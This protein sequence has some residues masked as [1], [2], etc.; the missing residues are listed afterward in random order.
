MLIDLML[1][2]AVIFC[3][4]QAVRARR[5]LTAVLWLAACSA[6][7][8]SLIY[9]TG[10]AETA[11]IELSVGAGLVTVLF[12]FCIAMIGRNVIKA[13]SLVPPR[14]AWLLLGATALFLG[15]ALWPSGAVETAVIS[16]PSFSVVFWEDRSL[17]V[18]VQIGLIFAGVMAI[19]GL[20]SEPAAV[21]AKKKVVNPAVPIIPVP[22]PVMSASRVPARLTPEKEGV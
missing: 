4:L 16:E 3:G 11:V 20:L 13:P 18:L 8:A 5:L 14:L 12:V 21:K 9:P 2:G 1:V 6:L 17:D 22:Q 10:A 19:L 15:R 7:T